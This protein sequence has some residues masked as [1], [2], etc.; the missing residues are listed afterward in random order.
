MWPDDS[1]DRAV[2]IAWRESRHQPTA[3]NACCYGLFQIHY[4]AHRAWLTRY[5]VTA[6][7][8]LL[9]PATNITVALALYGQAGWGP[10]KL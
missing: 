7:A 6:P 3:A 9:D 4:R 1:E 8:D 5:G 10:W 2:Q